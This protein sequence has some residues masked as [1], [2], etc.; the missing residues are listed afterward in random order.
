MTNKTTADVIFNLRINDKEELEIIINGKI[1]K[2]LT[3]KNKIINTKDIYFWLDYKT[4]SIYILD[5]KKF[6]DA[7]VSGDANEGKRLFNYVYDLLDEIIKEV[8]SYTNKL[9]KENK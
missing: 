9:Q 1:I 4:S 2:K 5:C 6:D 7:E 3:K 8:N